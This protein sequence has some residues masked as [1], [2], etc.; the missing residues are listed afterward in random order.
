MKNLVV[1][2]P[3]ALAAAEPPCCRAHAR[4][5]D[6]EDPWLC[7]LNY[8]HPG[9]HTAQGHDGRVYATWED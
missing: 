8:G 9:H 7:T 2:I 4:D 6:R 5:L 3:P 1:Y